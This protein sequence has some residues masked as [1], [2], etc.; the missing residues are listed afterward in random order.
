MGVLNVHSR[1]YVKFDVTNPN[2]RQW[3]SSSLSMNSWAK[4]PVRFAWTMGP[5]EAIPQLLKWYSTLEFGSK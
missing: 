2:H 1:P 3:V 5:E 4:V